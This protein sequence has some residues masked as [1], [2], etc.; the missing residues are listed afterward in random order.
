LAVGRRKRFAGGT[1][2]ATTPITAVTAGAAPADGSAAATV[3]V[4]ATNQSGSAVTLT[5]TIANVFNL[6]FA[7]SLGANVTY[8]SP[9]F[10]LMGGETIVLTAGTANALTYNV[11]GVEAKDV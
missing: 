1:L 11:T 6:A 7:L 2:T 8:V 4:M 9:L 5:V 3:V 10:D